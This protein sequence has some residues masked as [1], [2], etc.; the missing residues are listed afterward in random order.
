MCQQASGHPCAGVCAAQHMVTVCALSSGGRSVGPTRTP[1]H[2]PHTQA[3]RGRGQP[4]QAFQGL[5]WPRSAAHQVRRT[6]RAE[7]RLM[8]LHLLRV[9][10]TFCGSCG[11]KACMR[12]GVLHHPPVSLNRCPCPPGS[13]DAQ[14]TAGPPLSP[15]SRPRARHRHWRA[16]HHMRLACTRWRAFNRTHRSRP[17]RQ[18][19]RAHRPH[20]SFAPRAWAF[21]IAR[22]PRDDVPACWVHL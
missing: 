20:H 21:S 16:S 2:T 22:P 15:T 14:P 13:M 18:H 19:L 9:A 4:P 5:S 7:A 17:P 1:T 6:I 8:R 10:R 3:G 11:G 12:V